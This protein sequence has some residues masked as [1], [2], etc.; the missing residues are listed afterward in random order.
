MLARRR[1]QI[2]DRVH[3]ERDGRKGEGRVVGVATE[4]WRAGDFIYDASSDSPRYIVETDEG[5]RA[6]HRADELSGP[7][8]GAA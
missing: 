2:G 8:P 1:F 4:S 3:W 5:R 6:A 7:R